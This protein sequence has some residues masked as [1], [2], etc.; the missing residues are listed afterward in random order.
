MDTETLWIL[1]KLAA[2][3]ITA[4]FADR[5]LRGLELLRK[6]EEGESVDGSTAE[7]WA[8]PEVAEAAQETIETTSEDLQR[9]DESASEGTAQPG[10]SDERPLLG[11]DGIGIIKDIPDGTQLILEKIGDVTIQGWDQSYLRAEGRVSSST[12]L[13]AG[14]SLK[15]W[16]EDD[17]ALYIPSAVKEINIANG[18]GAIDI[19]KYPNDIVIDSDIGEINISEANGSIK[20]GSFEGDVTLENCR[21]VAS[22]E[23]SSGNITVRKTP[24]APIV[25]AGVLESK[26]EDIVMVTA[27]SVEAGSGGVVL[28]DIGGDIDLRTN[29]G[30]I[31]LERCSGQNI[32]V[33]SSG[34]DIILRDMTDS[35]NLRNEN[36]SIVVEGFSGAVSIKSRNTEIS[37]R[38][39]GDAEIHIDSEDGNINI[40]DCYADVYIDSVKGN[41]LISGGDHSSGGMGNVE[42]RMKVGDAYLHR[43]TFGDVHIVIGEGSAEVTMEKLNPGKSGQI[44]VYKGNVTVGVS[45]DF[46]CELTLLG[47]RENMRI[48]L[49]IEIT[50]RDKSHLRGIL[51]GGG[52][53]ME[54]IAPNGAIRFHSLKSPHIQSNIRNTVNDL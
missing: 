8:V 27:V 19:R 47:S 37:L 5:I 46:G 17:T 45:P 12:V 33:E 14:K 13:E 30:N 36:G 34:G 4:Q 23:S 11:D 3:E 9:T 50:E 39:S 29:S 44:S 54:V 25:P 18:S 10:T 42:L 35:M 26:A 53:K 21:G 51:N 6:I 48:E 2:R 22:L 15:I 31:T 28:A 7:E 49:P 32:D 1:K 20:I 52:S 38:D 43:R 24:T 40:K 16:S 41:V